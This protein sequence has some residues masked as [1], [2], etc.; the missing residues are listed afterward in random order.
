MKHLITWVCGFFA[1]KVVRREAGWIYSENTVTGQRR[2]DWDGG[3]LGSLDGRFLR[4][5]DIL[6]NAFTQGVVSEA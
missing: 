5:G 4:P 6:N 3:T 1:W 2:C